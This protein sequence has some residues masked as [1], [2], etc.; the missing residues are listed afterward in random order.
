MLVGSKSSVKKVNEYIPSIR[1]GNSDVCLSSTAKNIG[2]TLDSH[3]SMV[4]QV[5]NLTRTCYRNLYYISK[6]RL[7]INQQ[8][9]TKLVCSLILSRLDYVNS[10]LY[11]IPDTLIR[12]LQLVQN[13]AARLVMRKKKCEHVTPLLQQLHWLPIRQRIDYKI[14][15]LTFKVIIGQAPLYISELLEFY[16]PQ[17]A[18]RSSTQ[19]LLKE[20]KSNQ[21]CVLC[22]CPLTMEQIANWNKRY[23]LIG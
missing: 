14:L 21:K 10:L 6:I 7:F 17:R 20:R 8:T 19:K 22:V 11:G 13:N 16:E 12:K 1:C 3:L 5:N 4:E 2:V 23:C 18:L 9:A 15:T